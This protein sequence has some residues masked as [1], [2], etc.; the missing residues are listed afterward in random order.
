MYQTIDNTLTITVNDW[1]EAGLTENQFK[2]DSSHGLLSIYRRGVNGNTLID[3]RSIKRPERLAVLERTYGKIEEKPRIS[4]F[5]VELDQEAQNSFLKYR[6]PDGTPLDPEKIKEYT[7]KASIFKGIKNGLHKQ[8]EARAKAGKR[9]NMGDFWNDAMNYYNELATGVVNGMPDKD[10]EFSAP[11]YTNKRSFERAFKEY[12][13]DGYM[14]II[15]KNQGNDSARIVS[16]SVE[17]LLVALW[18]NNDKPF[19]KEVHQLYLDFISGTKELF[20]KETGEVFKPEKFRHKGRG[21]EISEATVW[22]YLKDIVNETAAYAD[23]NGHFDYMNKKRPKHHRCLGKYSLSKITM[24]DAVLSRKSSRGWVSKYLAVDVVSGYW[25]RPAYVVGKPS[26]NTVYEC[27]RNMFC[28]LIELGLPMPGELEVEYHLMQ[29]LKWLND[30]FPFVR[31]C[32][33]PTEK[34]AEHNIKA[35]KYGVAKREGHTRGRWY[36]KHEAFRSIRNKV[37]GDFVEPTYQAQ[38]IVADDLADIEKHNNELH[39]LQKTYTGMTRRQVFLA[40]IN[41][42]LQPIE[43]WH[44]YRFIGNE[45]QTQIYNNDYCPVNHEEFEIMDL[46]TLKHLKPNNTEVMA[47]WL[48]LGNGTVDKVYLY[49][50]GVYVGEAINRAKTAYNE[51]AFE[52][53]DEDKANMLIQNKR[54]KEFDSFIKEVRTEFPK[55]GVLNAE[56]SRAIKEASSI[57]I[58]IVETTQPILDDDNFEFT[59]DWAKQAINNL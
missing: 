14:S 23:R 4:I 49:Q 24:D 5:N 19:I 13:N 12:L 53:T 33:S 18:K 3:V 21:L 15:H 26:H 46:N 29:D 37:A 44:L 58:P 22:N 38:N 28:E 50:D 57:D 39:P 9:I 40:N 59:N 56:I 45:T 43:H 31:F 34:R 6:K 16:S 52:R 1:C 36:A 10:P 2:K 11:M 27:F 51:N 47:Y 42:N 8:I 32:E 17:K 54:V 30:L 25:F 55:V 20:D 48:P 35:L 7:N 41:P